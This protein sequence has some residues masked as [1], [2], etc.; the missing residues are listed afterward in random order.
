MMDDPATTGLTFAVR[1][2]ATGA[3]APIGHVFGGLG[4]GVSLESYDFRQ[5][6]DQFSYTWPMVSV[7]AGG[8]VILMH[9]VTIDTDPLAA[10][11]TAVSLVYLWN[12]AALEGMS[13]QEMQAVRNFVIW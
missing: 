13:T 5:S 7:P 4:A 12:P 1:Y 11:A 8:T 9:F 10:E 3:S 6:T 2:S